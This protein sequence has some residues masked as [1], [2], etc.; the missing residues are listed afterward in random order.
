MKKPTN[1]TGAAQKRVFFEGFFGHGKKG[2]PSALTTQMA[3]G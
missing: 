3:T 1:T 2:A